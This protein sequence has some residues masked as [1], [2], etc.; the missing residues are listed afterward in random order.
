MDG[1]NKASKF[2]TLLQKQMDDLGGTKNPNFWYEKIT[3]P[4]KHRIVPPIFGW[5]HLWVETPLFVAFLRHSQPPVQL[6]ASVVRLKSHDEWGTTWPGSRSQGGWESH[7]GIKKSPF[8]WEKWM[9]IEKCFWNYGWFIYLGSYFDYK[10]MS[11]S[12]VMFIDFVAFWTKSMGSM[13][14]WIRLPFTVPFTASE[15]YSGNLWVP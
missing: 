6:P 14:S 7:Q 5:K 15:P 4:K 3:A 10:K 11:L 2:Q 8:P 12:L 1:E 9:K 13:L